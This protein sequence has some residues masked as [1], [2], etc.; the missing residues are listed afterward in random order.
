MEIEDRSREATQ[1]GLRF[2]PETTSK[3]MQ[4]KDQG[5]IIYANILFENEQYLDD[6]RLKYASFFTLGYFR[7]GKVPFIC[8][9]SADNRRFATIKS[10][11]RLHGDPTVNRDY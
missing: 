5:L 8:R 9:K 7:N 3:R 6:C 10:T 1:F 11:A 4:T 2:E